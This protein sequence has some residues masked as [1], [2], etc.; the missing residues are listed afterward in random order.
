MQEMQL[1]L[2]NGESLTINIG[3]VKVYVWRVDDGSLSI[4]S[5]ANSACDDIQIEINAKTGDIHSIKYPSSE[6]VN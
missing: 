1:D 5:A 6:Q 4:S 3:N 2:D